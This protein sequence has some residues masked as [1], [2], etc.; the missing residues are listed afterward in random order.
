MSKNESCSARQI[1]QNVKNEQRKIAALEHLINK[2]EI[3]AACEMDI[4]LNLTNVRYFSA[5]YSGARNA[6]ELVKTAFLPLMK[7]DEKVYTEAILRLATSSM[8]KARMLIDE[9]PI[10]YK[11]HERDKKG[12]LIRCDAVF[13]RKV[14]KMEELE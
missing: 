6:L 11:N 5:Y 2:I 1:K 10:I 9:Y 4:P 8:D 14:V 7:G 13:A 12:K 3:K